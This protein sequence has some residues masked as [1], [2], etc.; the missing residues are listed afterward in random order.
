M[1]K[2]K[3]GKLPNVIRD[4]CTQALP[5]LIRPPTLIS[6]RVCINAENKAWVPRLLF[7]HAPPS[8]PVWPR[9]DDVRPADRVTKFKYELGLLEAKFNDLVDKVADDLNVHEVTVAKVKSCVTPIQC[10]PHVQ[11]QDNVEHVSAP[12][13]TQVMDQ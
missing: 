13:N 11:D 7:S 2:I 8:Y 6:L 1:D 9:C 3:R 10:P 12:L 5:T 4:Q